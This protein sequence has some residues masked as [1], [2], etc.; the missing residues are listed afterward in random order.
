MPGQ[1]RAGHERRLPSGEDA[2][3]T[4]RWPLRSGNSGA[5]ATDADAAQLWPRVDVAAFVAAWRLHAA[6]PA[7]PARGCAAPTVQARRRNWGRRGGRMRAC[8]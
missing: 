3:R 1:L 7:T 2:L 6:P 8:G 5:G 4:P